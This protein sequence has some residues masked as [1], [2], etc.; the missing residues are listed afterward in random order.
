VVAEVVN[1]EKLWTL[2]GHT[3]YVRV[4]ADTVAFSPDSA[5]LAS[6]LRDRIVRLWDLTTRQRV[7]TL[8]EHINAV[9]TVE[10]SPDSA[11]LASTLE[12]WIVR[13]WDPTTG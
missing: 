6:A 8:E 1:L 4:R 13:P 2:E 10:F 12:D 7:Q 5:L 11:L 9:D 3:S